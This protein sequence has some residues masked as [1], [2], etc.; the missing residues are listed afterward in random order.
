M[1]KASEFWQSH[2]GFFDIAANMSDERFKGKY[3][4]KECHADDFD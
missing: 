4:G 1:L 2:T 3:Y